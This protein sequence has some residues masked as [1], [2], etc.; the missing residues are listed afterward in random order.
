MADLSVRPAAPASSPQTEPS[1]LDTAIRVGQRML[2]AYGDPSG[3]DIYAYAQAHGGLAEALRIMLRALG[4]E[5]DTKP[6]PSAVTEL[7]QLCRDDY[8]SSVDRRAQDHRDDAHLIEDATEAVAATMELGTRCPAAHGDDPTPCDGP[9]VV[10][11]LDAQNAG[12]QGCEH[13]GARLLASLDGGRVYSLPHAPAGTAIRVFKAAHNTRP[14][15]WIEDAP[16]T[17]PS[18]LSHAENRGGGEGK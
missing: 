3:Y 10:T 17:E 2:A 1:D 12:A 14:F 13:H 9:A 15:A 7:H 11:V 4:A 16:R 6:L 18:Q 5:P 8:A